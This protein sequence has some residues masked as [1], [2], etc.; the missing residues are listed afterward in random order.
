MKAGIAVQPKFEG[1]KMIFGKFREL[2]FVGIGGAGMSGIAEILSNLG[3][4]VSGSDISPSEITE[5]LERL[6]IKIYGEHKRGNIGTANVVVISSAVGNDNP[7]VIEAREKGIPVIKRAEMLGELM[8]LKYSIGIA[9]THGKTTTTSMI[10]KIF[11]EAKLDPTVIVGGIVAGTGSGAALGAGEYL[12]AE[13][14]EYDKS[15]LSMFPSM[16][17]VTN[18]EADHLDC[19]DGM[20]D[21]KNSFLAYMNRVPFYGTVVYGA[22]NPI[23]QKLQ[24][25]ISRA[26]VSFGLTSRADYQAVDIKY[27]EGGSEFSVFGR[28][29]M[30]GRIILNVPGEHNVLNAMA[31][32]AAALELEIPF[33]VIAEA[34][35]KFRTVGRRFEIK[36]VVNDIMVVDDYAHHPTEVAVTL[37]TARESYK[38]RVIAVFQPHLFSRTRQFFKEFADVLHQADVAYL[39]DIYPA[40]EKPMPG[41]TSEMILN[42][43][44]EKGYRNI[45]YI[46]PKE[47][48]IEAVIKIAQP[49]D[50]II[51]IGA[52][53]ITRINPEILKGIEKR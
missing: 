52:G 19:Y 13:A 7:E 25:R 50:I 17:V 33:G 28:G 30:V 47:N 12:V 2:Y 3:Y 21:L 45:H 8:R 5:Y 38:R 40:R 23:L 46:G 11:I 32:T 20:E 49:G 1:K 35:S 26:S 41:V 18:I 51:T 10:G 15:F 4:K 24:G 34:L 22:D 16:A 37:R 43:A 6:G 53:S 27:R 31:A 44:K 39:A 48:A 36:G 9:G 42:Y 14:D 29:E